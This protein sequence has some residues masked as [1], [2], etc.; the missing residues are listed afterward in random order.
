MNHKRVLFRT[1]AH[2]KIAQGVNAL[3][4]TVAITLGPKSKSVLI[5]KAWGVPLVCDDGVTIAKEFSLPDPEQDLGA[6]MLRQAAVR[7]GDAVGD[8]TTTSILLAKVIVDE[9]L[10]NVAAGASAVE[11]KR[12]LQ[13]GLAV[14]VSELKRLSRP[15]DSHRE[16]VQVATLSGHGDKQ[17]GALVA[18]AMEKVG[19][20]GVVSVEEAKGIETVL[21]I[22]DGLRFDRGYISPY[23][24]TD[25]KKMEAS[26]VDS[27]LL[28]CERKISSMQDLLPLLE[29]TAQSGRA[30]CIIAEDIEAE[31]LAT[32]VVNKV[33]GSLACCAVKAPGFGDRR[34]ALLEDIAIVTGAH[35]ISSD[36]G[37]RLDKLTES[38]LGKAARIVVSRDT[39]TIVGGAGRKEAIEGR[40]AELRARI[41]RAESDYDREHLEERLAKLSGGV[42]VIRVGAPS[43]SEMRNRKDAFDDAIASTKAAMEEGIV[44]GGGWSLL[45][46]LD[47]LEALETQ[48][49][50]G[51]KTGV[52]IL[53]LALEAPT[54][55]IAKNSDADDGVVVERVRH[56][57]GATGFDATTGS[58][59]DLLQSG[60]VDSTKVVRVALENAVSVGGVL[61]LT[62]ATLTDLPDPVRHAEGPREGGQEYVD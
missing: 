18:E 5:A 24:V 46:S 58:F 54:R 41:A 47:A 55:R 38:D 23:F 62:D 50:G 25:P 20:E 43:E 60:I 22:V 57:D 56:G 11:I 3:A 61:L 35:F 17:L 30:L 33:R 45:H 40:C 51:E 29:Q 15:I 8:G 39:T 12:G 2:R 36:A 19:G 26:L 10:K 31:A 48:L 13:R 16:R 27:A 6:Q 59:I 21:E 42:A 28:V 1:E 49:D 32:L 7:T 34:K 52:H 44:P 53:R 9:G 4:E 14:V 37:T